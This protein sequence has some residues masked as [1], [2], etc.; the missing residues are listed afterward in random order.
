M[1]IIE[2][3]WGKKWIKS[4]AQEA[5]KKSKI[6]FNYREEKGKIKLSK[7]KLSNMDERY[8]N[9]GRIIGRY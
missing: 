1:E 3:E 4:L 2:K 7:M 9:K 5:V 6:N 8:R